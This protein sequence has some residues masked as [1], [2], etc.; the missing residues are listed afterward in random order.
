MSKRGS[1]L[2]CP[3]GTT[4]L[5]GP[6]AHAICVT[7]FETMLHCSDSSSLKKGLSF[8]RTVRLY[9]TQ[10]VLVAG[11]AAGQMVLAG[12]TGFFPKAQGRGGSAELPLYTGPAVFDVSKLASV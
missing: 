10:A 7:A 5:P 2:R 12:S 1:Y 4:S 8:L 9:C 3:V 6:R 11:R